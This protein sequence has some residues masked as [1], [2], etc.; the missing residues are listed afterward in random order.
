ML[1]HITKFSR[2]QINLCNVRSSSVVD[3]VMYSFKECNSSIHK[4]QEKGGNFSVPF[5]LTLL[6]KM[7]I[8]CCLCRESLY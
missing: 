3:Y 1:M 2:D 4:L 6:T 8:N 7:L 5:Y